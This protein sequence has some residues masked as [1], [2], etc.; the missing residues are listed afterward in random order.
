M[1]KRV[2]DMRRL[3]LLTPA[4][5]CGGKAYAS[6][7]YIREQVSK[8]GVPFTPEEYEATLTGLLR[9]EARAMVEYVK[10]IERQLDV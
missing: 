3:D 4:A 7:E 1:S 6:A 2:E 9:A 10:E 5:L 8:L